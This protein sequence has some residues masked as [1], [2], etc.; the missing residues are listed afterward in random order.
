MNRNQ[1][2]SPIPEQWLKALSIRPPD[3]RA[4]MATWMD[5]IVRR[6][7]L[8]VYEEMLLDPQV[9]ASLNLL[10]S[11]ALSL[12]FNVAPRDDSDDAKGAEVAQE[13]Q[14]MLEAFPG[15]VTEFMY[16]ALSA[17]EYGWSVTEVVWGATSDKKKWV[18]TKWVPLPQAVYGFELDDKT[19]DPI[20]V[21]T[22]FAPMSTGKVWPLEN[23]FIMRWNSRFGAPYGRSQLMSAYEAWWIKQ[24]IR[25]MRNTALDR[26]GS[27][28]I[29]A[30]VP[31]G[32]DKKKRDAI[33]EFIENLYAESGL[34]ADDNVQI[35]IPQ[36][37]LGQGASQGFQAAIDYEDA[38]IAKGI[39]GA[40]LNANES[41][42]TGTYAQAK[43]HQD[44][45]L[46]LV[47]R[48]SKMLEETIQR[49]IVDRY[50]RYNYNMAPEETP[51]VSFDSPETIDLGMMANVL[52]ALAGIQAID[53]AGSDN[54]WIREKLN[55][56]PKQEDEEGGQQQPQDYSDYF[57][58]LLNGYQDQDQESA[59]EPGGE[60][61]SDEEYGE[62]GLTGRS[63]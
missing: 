47:A 17:L 21:R 49:Q 53:P 43:V 41:R 38:Q 1:K 25:R 59:Q 22:W 60:P 37:G 54:D 55:L 56:P 28:L 45:F 14:Q 50:C 18:P 58:Q 3:F 13:V 23:F 33:R 63:S 5:P 52:T 32:Y 8:S 2:L 11:A 46:Y 30:K 7:G 61:P 34:V 44:N 27:P 24:L 39:T 26:F 9:Y 51:V 19:G 29:F 15:G 16:N 12:D 31:V 36:P 57:R 20:G 10:K 40:T 6:K 4:L 42:G 35:E 48:V 62:Q